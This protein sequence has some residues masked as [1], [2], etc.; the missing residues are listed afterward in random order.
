M[1]FVIFIFI[2][3]SVVSPSSLM[4]EILEIIIKINQKFYTHIHQ[5][6]TR[7]LDPKGAIIFIINNIL[8][9]F[10]FFL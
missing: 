1:I 10:K 7:I 2:F 5:L 8:K 9:K 6:E 3:I 4:Q